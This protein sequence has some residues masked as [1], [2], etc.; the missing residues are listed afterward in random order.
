MT[1]FGMSIQILQTY[2]HFECLHFIN[3]TSLKKSILHINF[4]D[5][6]FYI[7]MIYKSHQMLES[8][9]LVKMN[10]QFSYVL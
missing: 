3:A 10:G 2:Q 6:K 8:E 9:T 5:Y 7:G 4:E 1:T